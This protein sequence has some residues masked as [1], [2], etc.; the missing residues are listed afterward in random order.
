MTGVFTMRQSFAWLR[1]VALAVAMTFHALAICAPVISDKSQKE[2]TA[3]VELFANSFILGTGESH[4][5]T[6]IE[7]INSETAMA[8]V[9]SFDGER[10]PD[11]YT[12]YLK[13]IEGKWKVVRYE[14]VFLGTEKKESRE[15]SPP[16]PYPNWR[17]NAP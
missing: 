2:L 5:I 8:V 17:K 3:V 16:F 4:F 12:V 7:A 15:Q 11:A 14:F 10:R 13:K 9:G 6:S 1:A